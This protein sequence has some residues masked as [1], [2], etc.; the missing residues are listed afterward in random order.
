MGYA[1]ALRLHRLAEAVHFCG[2][3]EALVA[4]LRKQVAG[5]GIHYYVFVDDILCVGD[6]EE[7]TREGCRV[8]EAEFRARGVQWAPN[9]TRGPCQCIEF[10]GLLLSN[11]E[12]QRGVTITRK[13]MASTLAEIEAWLT[14]RPDAGWLQVDP[15]ELASLLG[16]LIFV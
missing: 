14:R 8:L 13:R 9:K 4:R 7:L 16:K 3:T 5:R 2:L 12:G 10:L 15:K 6:T 11:V 1:T